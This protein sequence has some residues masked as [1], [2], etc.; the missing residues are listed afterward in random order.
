[1]TATDTVSNT[2]KTVADVTKALLFVNGQMLFSGDSTP[3]FTITTGGVI[4]W[5]ATNA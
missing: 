3:A 5:N 2:T 4:T 1:V